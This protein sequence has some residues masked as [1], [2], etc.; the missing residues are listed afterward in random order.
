MKINEQAIARTLKMCLVDWRSDG[1][2]KG[3][4]IMRET[5]SVQSKP[6]EMNF[7]QLLWVAQQWFCSF[8]PKKWN[9]EFVQRK[10]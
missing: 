6:A 1:R 5:F 4:V 2:V 3:Y 9:D 10:A 7:R 8:F